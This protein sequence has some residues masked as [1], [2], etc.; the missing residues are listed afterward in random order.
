[1]HLPSKLQRIVVRRRTVRVIGCL[2]AGGLLSGCTSAAFSELPAPIGLPEGAPARSAI[3]PEYPAVH[4][5]PPPRPNTVMTEQ[6][7]KDLERE[8]AAE[9]ERLGRVNRGKARK[10]TAKSPR[11][12]RSEPAGSDRN[13]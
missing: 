6:E 12:T 3:Q 9:R 2:L 7:R 8:L 10:K 11:K 1:M 4:D 13:P 5:I